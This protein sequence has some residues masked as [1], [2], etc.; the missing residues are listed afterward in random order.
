MTEAHTMKELDIAVLTASNV[1]PAL[2]LLIMM[3]L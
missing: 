1:M 2:Q 3:R